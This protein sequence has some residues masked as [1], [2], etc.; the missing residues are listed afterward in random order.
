MG[1]LWNDEATLMEALSEVENDGR[2]HDSTLEGSET[3]E[4]PQIAL[5]NTEKIVKFWF[6]ISTPICT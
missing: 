2:L 5:N 3:S 4:T 6:S 1:E